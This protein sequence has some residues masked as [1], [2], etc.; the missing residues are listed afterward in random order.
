MPIEQDREVED[1][2][3]CH[4]IVACDG[5][6]VVGFAGTS[7][8]YFAWLYV[9]PRE[10]GRGIGRLLLRAALPL[11]GKSAWTIVLD[12]NV[13]A[14]RL[15]E[16]EGFRIARTWQ[17]DNAGY[18]CTCL[19]MERVEDAAQTPEDEGRAGVLRD[20]AGAIAARHEQKR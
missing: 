9:H 15:Y 6:R 18:P 12:G 14:R 1:L 11:L 5:D 10:Y 20:P 19:R 2:K 16:S 13:R 17:G 7:N 8:E 3:R 4:K